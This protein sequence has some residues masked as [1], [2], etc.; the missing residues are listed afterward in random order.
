MLIRMDVPIAVLRDVS[1]D[2]ATEL[3]PA[4][5]LVLVGEDVRPVATQPLGQI[6]VGLALPQQP[7]RLHIVGAHVPADVLEDD[8]PR[9][10]GH[11]TPHELLVLGRLPARVVGETL[12]A[13]GPRDGR[14]IADRV[15]EADEGVRRFGPDGAPMAIEAEQDQALPMLRHAVSE[16]VHDPCVD[17][18]AERTERL[19]EVDEDRAVVPARKV[20]HVLDQHG[21][22][23]EAARPPRRTRTRD[24]HAG[25]APRA[26]RA[27]PGRGS[28]T[29][30]PC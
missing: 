6:D 25:R 10:R 29:R 4:Q 8:V 11:V 26:R 17:A 12:R 23:A 14:K 1:G 19:I 30:R 13:L 22:A 9:V 24:R 18:V 7:E 15:P 5:S 20:R 27:R 16:T 21:G 28:A 3:R 2:G